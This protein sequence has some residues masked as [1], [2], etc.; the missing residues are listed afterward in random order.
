MPM[1]HIVP[2][3]CI[4]T[5]TKMVELDIM[6]ERLVQ[7]VALEEDRFISNFH[8]QVQKARE[9]AWH[10]RHIRLNVFKEEDLVLLYD[11]Q[12]L[13]HPGKFRKHWL[14][15]YIMKEITDG[16]VVRLATLRSEIL[17]GY[18]NGSRLKPYRDNP[19]PKK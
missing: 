2:S 9:K 4:T 1:D 19:M 6:E 8:Q 18:F 14:G 5:F 13:H 7:L 10:D 15:P 11:S 17:P 12:F 16:G 3:L